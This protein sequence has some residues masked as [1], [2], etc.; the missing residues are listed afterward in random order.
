[1]ITKVFDKDYLLEDLEVPYFGE[2]VKEDKIVDTDRWSEH[3]VVIFEDDGQF[4]KTHYSKG[5]TEMQDEMPW[6]YEDTVE[7]F[8]V[9]EKEVLVKKWVEVE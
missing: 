2:C 3:H 1:M 8:L 4:W 5:L 7:A 6:E 9:E